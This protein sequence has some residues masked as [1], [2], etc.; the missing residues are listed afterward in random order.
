MR[1]LLKAGA[2]PDLVDIRGK[3]AQVGFRFDVCLLFALSNPALNVQVST[4]SCGLM[5][6]RP[7]RSGV[8][9]SLRRPS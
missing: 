7:Q 1:A 8:K 9:D 5:A 2:S 6:L 4:S 3:P